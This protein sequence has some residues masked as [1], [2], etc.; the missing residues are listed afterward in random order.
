MVVILQTGVRNESL[1]ATKL[2][3]PHHAA[4]SQLKSLLGVAANSD[5]SKK[6]AW[7]KTQESEILG[8]DA[9]TKSSLASIQIEQKRIQDFDSQHQESKHSPNV[10]NAKS[11]GNSQLAGWQLPAS[12]AA[13]SAS[14]SLREIM[15][16]EQEMQIR[17]DK[18]QLPTSVTAN[19]W[20]AKAGALT[21]N[22]NNLNTYAPSNISILSRNVLKK[23][24]LTSP[25]NDGVFLPAS[26]LAKGHTVIPPES[27]IDELKDSGMSRDF[28]SWCSNQLLKIN[29]S[30]DLTLVKFCVSLESATEIRE[31][32]AAYLGS[33]PQVIL[34]LA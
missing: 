7:K 29:G 11:T 9:I 25:S 6:V 22:G 30:K 12:E 8:N 14:L 2:E 1:S 23:E 19:S 27:N 31:Y 20:A 18:S 34:T 21:S 10:M 32:L 16:Q 26:N 24:P 3:K 17:R 15:I 4:S 5:A 13:K 33:T 28:A